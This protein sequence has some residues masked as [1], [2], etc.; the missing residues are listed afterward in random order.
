MFRRDLI[1]LLLDRPMSLTQIAREVGESPKDVSE[2]LAHLAKSVRHTEHELVIEPAECRRCGFEF[3]PDKFSR[4]S[5]CPQCK[6]TWIAEP[7]FSVRPKQQ[8]A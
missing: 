5:K 6:G 3:R 1:P 4:P 2:A 7:F 8:R